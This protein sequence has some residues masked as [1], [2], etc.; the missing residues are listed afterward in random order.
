MNTPEWIKPALGGAAAGAI[1]LAV[2]GF[3]WGGWVTQSTA[4]SMAST[5][6]SEGMV[7]ALVPHCVARA[8]TDPE[9]SVILAELKA[10][11]NF[12]RRG[13]VEKAGWAT[14]IGEERPNRALATACST[15]LADL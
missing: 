1:A 12:N 3:T 5:A 2:V 7:A 6:A 9:A 14:P 8:S 13:V 11:S 10:A 4:A 15:A